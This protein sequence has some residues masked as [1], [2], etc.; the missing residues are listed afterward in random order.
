MKIV[1]AQFTY[2]ELCWLLESLDDY[3]NN[4]KNRG[5][6]VKNPDIF[7]VRGHV[8]N[9]MKKIERSNRKE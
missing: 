4:A 7:R 8:I 3:L 5:I 2:S 1:K 9:L 6:I